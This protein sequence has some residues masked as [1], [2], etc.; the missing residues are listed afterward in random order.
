V[1][2][3]RS[4]ECEEYI[5]LDGN[6]SPECCHQ[7]LTPK[8]VIERK[9]L[10]RP[11]GKPR[12]DANLLR[13]APVT[14]EN[15]CEIFESFAHPLLQGCMRGQDVRWVVAVGMIAWNIALLP[16]ARREAELKRL[17]GE[18][19]MATVIGGL[20][21]RKRALFGKIHRYIAQY[22]LKRQGKDFELTIRWI[23][24]APR[25]RRRK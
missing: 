13:P 21:C 3:G 11:A 23:P 20:V 12:I 2:S 17:P 9:M 10:T 7:H 16:K 24:F 1:S 15:M 8:F 6:S 5:A 19:E 4:R 25:A 14:S 18:K 22:K